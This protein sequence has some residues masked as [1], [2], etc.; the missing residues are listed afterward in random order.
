MAY[1]VVVDGR[2]VLDAGKATAAGIAYHS[3]G[4]PGATAT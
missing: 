2:N 1:P 3:V 4:R